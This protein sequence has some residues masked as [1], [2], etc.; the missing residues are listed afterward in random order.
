MSLIKMTGAEV[1]KLCVEAIKGIKAERAKRIEK[2]EEHIFVEANKPLWFWP[3]KKLVTREE[4]LEMDRYLRSQ[5]LDFSEITY[6]EVSFQG[7]QRTASD[8][9]NAV[10]G[11]LD[12]E[13][14][15]DVETVSS[16]KTWSY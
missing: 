11:N 8:L 16:L 4:A 6:A 3:W 15:V 12:K 9:L 10:G 7:I 13:V 14:L 1:Q 5:C 2:A